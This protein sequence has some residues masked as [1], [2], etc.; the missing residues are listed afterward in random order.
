MLKSLDL[1]S[2]QDR[3]KEKRLCFLYSIQKGKVPA[4]NTNEYLTPIKSKR[5]IKA[6]N[7][8]DC[9]TQDIIKRHQNLNS[10]CFQLPESSNNVYKNSFF[11]KSISEWNELPESVVNAPSAETFKSRLKNLN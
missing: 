3:R 7:Y 4:I 8:S 11:P 1:Q 9:V 10:K 5:R 6:R 2:L